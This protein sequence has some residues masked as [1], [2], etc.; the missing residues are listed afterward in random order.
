[1]ATASIE[2]ESYEFDTQKFLNVELIAIERETGFTSFEWQN[3]LNQG[4]MIA[5]TGLIWVL[6]KRVGKVQ[7][8]DE[9]EFETSTL[10]ID[11]RSREEVAAEKAEA[12]ARAASASTA[13]DP[14]PS[15]PTPTTTTSSSSSSEDG[16][17]PPSATS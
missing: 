14:A 7:A 13:T 12:E 8:F 17:N 2:G 3:K 10:V 6:R 16:S 9:V 11:F 1:M 4:S 15:S 5:A